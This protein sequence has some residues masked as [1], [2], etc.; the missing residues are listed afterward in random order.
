MSIPRPT[1]Q[2]MPVMGPVYPP[3]VVPRPAQRP[4]PAPRPVESPVIRRQHSAE[5]LPGG[6]DW[7][8]AANP[9]YSPYPP[10]SGQDWGYAPN[11]HYP[12]SSHA[13]RGSVFHGATVTAPPSRPPAPP[14]TREA[15]RSSP[16]FHAGAPTPPLRRPETAYTPQQL[17]DGVIHSMTVINVNELP[18]NNPNISSFHVTTHQIGD[19]ARR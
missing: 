2:S 17:R 18:N 7:G 9:N 3:M 15:P 5:S 4:M 10:G 11:P 13:A 8:Y 19:V 6:L 1:Q 16:Q 12:Q 14:L